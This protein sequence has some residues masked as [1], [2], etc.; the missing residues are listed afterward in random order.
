[1]SLLLSLKKVSDGNYT[2][3][4]LNFHVMLSTFHSFLWCLLYLCVLLPKHNSLSQVRKLPQF[5]FP[6]WFSGTASSFQSSDLDPGLYFSCFAAHVLWLCLC[7]GSSAGRTERS[8]AC[9][10]LSPPPLGWL[11]RIAFL[12]L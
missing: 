12:T 3:D 7:L 5:L 8:L 4:L 9:P 2:P 10:I 11:E 6:K 1:M